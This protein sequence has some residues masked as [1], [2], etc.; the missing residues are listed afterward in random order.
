MYRG[1][2]D[3]LTFTYT[4]ICKARGRIS[5]KEMEAIAQGAHTVTKYAPAVL[6]G[7]QAIEGTKED[8]LDLEEAVKIDEHI[9]EMYTFLSS[10]EIC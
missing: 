2:I 7:A 8:A 1:L 10:M 5:N 4:Y 6:G 9:D 3:S